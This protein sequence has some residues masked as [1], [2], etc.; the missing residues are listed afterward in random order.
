MCCLLSVSYSDSDMS[1]VSSDPKVLDLVVAV[2]CIDIY[3]DPSLVSVSMCC[4]S[5]IG[6]VKYGP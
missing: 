3:I 1:S 5:H 2:L 6:T 4:Y